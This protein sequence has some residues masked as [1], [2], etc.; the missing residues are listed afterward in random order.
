VSTKDKSKL[1]FIRQR[2][3]DE[4]AFFHAMLYQQSTATG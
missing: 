2:Q 1:F 3:T 4:S